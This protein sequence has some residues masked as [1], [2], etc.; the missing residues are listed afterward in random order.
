MIFFLFETTAC[1]LWETCVTS[2]KFESQKRFSQQKSC[3]LPRPVERS[4]CVSKMIRI[5]WYI[6]P[7][8]YFLTNVLSLKILSSIHFESFN[9]GLL[10]VFC[11]KL[12]WHHLNLNP[13]IVSNNRKVVVC[14]VRWRDQP[15]FR[16]WYRYC[17]TCIRFN[18]LE[19]T[20]C[21]DLY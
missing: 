21:P 5:L 8:E 12:L 1:L 6:Y 10:L 11:E 14:R 9:V 16:E 18:H 2:L 4:S 17:D 20:F 7:F 15:V 3:W 13:K 19:Q